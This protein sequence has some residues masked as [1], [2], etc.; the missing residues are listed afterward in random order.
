MQ[1]RSDVAEATRKRTVS[2]SIAQ[3]RLDFGAGLKRAQDLD[4]GDR[5][6]REIGRNVGGDNRQAENLDMKRFAGR[7]DRLKIRAAVLPQ[8]KIEL[9][10]RNGLL[11]RIGV[12]VELAADRCPDEVRAIGMK[13]LPHEQIDMAEVDESHVDREF[14]AVHDPERYFS[15][16]F[17][18]PIPS[19]QMAHG[20]TAG[21]CKGL[22][23]YAGDLDQRTACELCMADVSCF[24][25][26]TRMPVFVPIGGGGAFARSRW[27]DR[28]RRVEQRATP[29]M[30][31]EAVEGAQDRDLVGPR[32]DC[33]PAKCLGLP[34]A[35][36]HLRSEPT[37]M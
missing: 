24:F 7:T 31:V 5:C 37:E 25:F 26:A 4:G 36:W 1:R 33:G 17:P 28:F 15:A 30:E 29:E 8:T 14:F 20:V 16:I 19:T 11:H 9:A 35:S 27:R 18:I 3:G 23:G 2:G 6:P 13:A 32:K 34:A 22:S 12:T 21:N 10:S